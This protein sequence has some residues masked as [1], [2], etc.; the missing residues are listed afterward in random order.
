MHAFEL[1]VIVVGYVKTTHKASMYRQLVPTLS[2]DYS[3]LSC[4]GWTDES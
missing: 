4:C 3:W 1:F 2:A